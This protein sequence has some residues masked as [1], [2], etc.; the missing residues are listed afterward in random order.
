MSYTKHSD[1]TGSYH[2]HF[3]RQD[4]AKREN[5]NQGNQ[6]LA[7]PKP[8]NPNQGFPKKGF[9]QRISKKDSVVRKIDSNNTGSAGA[10][11]VRDQS[12]PKKFSDEDFDKFWKFCREHWFGKPGHKHEARKE[13]DKLTPGKDDLREILKLTRNEC[14]YRRRVE[15]AEGF[16]ESMKHVCRWIKVRGW[17][18]VRDRIKSSPALSVVRHKDPTSVN[19]PYRKMM[20]KPDR[21]DRNQHRAEGAA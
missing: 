8:E 11:P 4:S 21:P 7:N 1:G 6:D 14:D 20:V 9:P 3:E 12:S 5:P 18:D 19:Q 17:E 2:L 15:A 10:D 13:F 16:C